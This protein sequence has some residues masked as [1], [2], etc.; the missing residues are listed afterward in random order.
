MADNERLL[1]EARSVLQVT[2]SNLDGKNIPNLRYLML[3]ESES[4][5]GSLLWPSERYKSLPHI[6]L[7]E[8]L[9]L[10]Q[11]LIIR[12]FEVLQSSDRQLMEVYKT[13]SKT[14]KG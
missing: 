2:F 4:Q 8:G 14:T 9:S 6:T 12:E 3:L 1:R 10:N 7:P 5:I 13:W 11:P